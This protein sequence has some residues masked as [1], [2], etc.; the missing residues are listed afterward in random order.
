MS[1]RIL[2]IGLSGSIARIPASAP[3]QSAARRQSWTAK[4]LLRRQRVP[5]SRSASLPAS[6]MAVASAQSLSS[7]DQAA[8]ISALRVTPT[9]P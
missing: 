7:I 6:V 2:A 3:S 4:E 9:M 5:V 1:R 8:S